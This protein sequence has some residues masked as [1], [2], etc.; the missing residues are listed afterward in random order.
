MYQK[1][2]FYYSMLR[3]IKFFIVFNFF[4]K[5][6]IFFWL[7]IYDEVELKFDTFI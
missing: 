3:D 7:L 1:F 4:F 6:N 5:F 2:K